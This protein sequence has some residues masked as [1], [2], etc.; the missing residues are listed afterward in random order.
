MRLHH[1]VR[2]DAVTSC[3]GSTYMHYTC[4]LHLGRLACRASFSLGALDSR[5]HE[6]RKCAGWALCC[7]FMRMSCALFLSP[8]YLAAPQARAAHRARTRARR[9]AVIENDQGAAAAVDDAGIYDGMFEAVSTSRV[10]AVPDWRAVFVLA[11]CRGASFARRPMPAR[12][13]SFAAH[14]FIASFE[15]SSHFVQ[16]FVICTCPICHNPTGSI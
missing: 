7:S 13:A 3:C 2:H 16:A 11:L 6:T 9:V 12:G 10:S 5:Q 15:S 8:A 1:T 4:F 14:S